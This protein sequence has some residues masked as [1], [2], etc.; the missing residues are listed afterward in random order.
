MIQQISAIEKQVN[1][2][3]SFSGG[4]RKS[5]FTSKQLNSICSLNG[6]GTFCIDASKYDG[7]SH[8]YTRILFKCILTW[9]PFWGF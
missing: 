4:I 7:V 6:L 1:P 2:L 9:I 5:S 3:E 8:T